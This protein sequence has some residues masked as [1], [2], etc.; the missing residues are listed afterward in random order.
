MKDQY[1]FSNAAQAKFFVPADEIEIPIYLDS[2]VFSYLRDKGA[3][4][5]TDVQTLVNDLLRKDFEMADHVTLSNAPKRIR[6]LFTESVEIRIP[7]YQRAYSWEDKQCAQFLDDLLGQNGKQYYLGQ[8]LFEKEADTLYVIDGQ[9]R[10]TTTVIFISA[11]VKILEAKGESVKEIKDTY[12]ADVFETI[13]DD[14]IIFKRITREHFVSAIDEAETLSQKR[15]ISAFNFFESKLTGMDDTKILYELF[16][17][18]SDSVISVFY[19]SSKIEATQVFEYQNNRGKGLSRFEVIKAFLMNQ[20]YITS[21]SF[22]QAT[23]KIKQI[24]RF[25]SKIYR[26]LESVEGF[27]T[28]NEVIDNYCGL[29]FNIEGTIEAIKDRL[30][31]EN[32][33]AKW[34]TDFFEKLAV[35]SHCAKSIVNHKNR[36]EISSLFFLGNEANWKLVVL[37]LVYKGDDKEDIFICILKMLEVLCFKL[38]LGDYRSDYLPRYAK[39]YFS[40]ED[41]CG[42]ESLRA[43]IYKAAET[44]F[45]LYWNDNG[46]FSKVISIY[47]DTEKYHYNTRIIKF[48]LWQYENSLRSKNRSGALLDKDLYDSYTIEHIAPQN[49]SNGQN[50]VEFEKSYL[51]LAGNLALLTQSQNSKFGNKSF[52][53]KTALFQDTALTSYTE[54]RA[55]PQWTEKEI[56]ERHKEISNFARNYFDI[57]AFKQCGRREQAEES[58]QSINNTERNEEQSLTPTTALT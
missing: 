30:T 9:Q 1:D 2:D 37:A 54:I 44:G 28:E 31:R 4:A 51:N 25:V 22:N 41:G 33:K 48:V 12:L 43:A 35:F 3:S 47:F 50:P 45:K 26:S 39:N 5:N 19:I 34:I 57:S 46:R 29:F 49:P 40:A 53:E 8:L 24:E 42:L 15:I 21:I 10:I 23:A 36:P 27:F 7:P 20:V 13:D 52:E 17:T 56:E 58:Q 55:K 11:L 18:L 14:Q 38:K 6:Q 32:D 16:H